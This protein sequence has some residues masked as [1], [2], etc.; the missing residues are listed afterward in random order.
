MTGNFRVVIK[1][2]LYP[3]YLIFRFLVIIR[4]KTFDWGWVKQEKYSAR[5]ISIGGISFGGAGKTP[6]TIFLAETAG[7]NRKILGKTAVISRGF[8]RSSKGMVVVSDSG[9][10]KVSVKEAG[11]EL[12]LL[13]K[14]CPKT[15]VAADA[16]RFEG[17]EYAIKQGCKTILLDDCF[18]HRFIHRDIDIVMLEPETVLRPHRYFQRESL[19]SL[20]RATAIVI[21]E[22]AIAK[23]EEIT[24]RL[25]KFSQAPIFWGRRIPQRI[26][27]LKGGNTISDETLKYRKTAA[28]CALANPTNFARTLNGLGIYPKELLAFPDHCRYNPPDLDKIARYFVTSGVEILLTTEK[29]AVKLPPL[30]HNLPIYYLTIGLQIEDAETLLKL[31]FAQEINIT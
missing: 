2:A 18:Q 7:K 20:K 16:I 17:A 26:K 9:K 27:S 21:L 24:R 31:V 22:A 3:F 11:D 25:S 1:T 6:M 28:F 15:V 8:G 4:N 13:A 23:R 14:R 5:V 10:I 29:D 30:L 19:K 12:Y